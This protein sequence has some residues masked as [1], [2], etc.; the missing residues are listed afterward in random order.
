MSDND[1][2]K[3][4]RTALG[5]SYLE[6]ADRLRLTGSSSERRDRVFDMEVGK[7]PVTGPIAAAVDLLA[8]KH[9]INLEG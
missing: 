9:A 1:K 8:E 6:M 2:L 3:L 7:R 5:W 4:L